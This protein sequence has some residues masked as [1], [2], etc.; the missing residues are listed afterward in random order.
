[1]SRL[2]GPDVA[3]YQ[4][5]VDWRKVKAAGH[6][7]AFIK[8]TEGTSY[9]NPTFSREWPEIKAAGLIRGAY[10]FGRPKS[11]ARAQARRFLRVIGGWQKGDLPPVLDIETSDGLPASR[12]RAWVAAFVDEIHQHTGIKPIVYTG[13]PFWRTNVGLLSNLGCPLWLAAYVRDPKPYV[14]GAWRTYSFWQYTSSAQVPG[15]AGRC[16]MSVWNGDLA[17]LRALARITT[18]REA[19][20][21]RLR[22][23]RTANIKILDRILKAHPDWKDRP[24]SWVRDRYRRAV[25]KR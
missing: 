20:D 12:V 4:G 9:I 16:D 21:K 19:Q 22:A 7:F 2:S 18:A 24:M 3:S 11:D 15:I 14:P 17:G 1:M 23:W 5:D 8:A 10:H 6:D 13:G 25:A